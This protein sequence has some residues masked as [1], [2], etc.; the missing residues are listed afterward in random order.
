MFKGGRAYIIIGILAFILLLIFE[1]NKPKTINWFPSYVTT[2]KIPYGTKVIND[3]LPK[4]LP[5][6]QQVY[7]TPYELLSRK[8]SL[9]GTYVF[10]NGS[11]ELGATD[12]EFLLSWVS[13]GN[14]LFMASESFDDKLLDTF[15]LE[16]SSLYDAESVQPIFKH[17][18]VNS[19]LTI[20]EIAF[21]RDYYSTHFSAIDTTNS[22]IIGQVRSENDS[23]KNSQKE[24]NVIQQ[25]FGD[26]K[27]TLS[28]FPE[29]F[30]NYF[31]L[32]D[33]NHKYTGGLLSYIDSSL[34]VFIDNHHKSGKTFYTSPMYLFLNTRSFKWAYYLVLIGALI[35]VIFEGKRK[36][37]AIKIVT[38]LKNQTLAFTRTIA[39]M[40]FENNRQSEIAQ[41]KIQYFLDYI[42]NRFYLGTEKLNATFYK[43]LA[44]RSN[45]SQEEV[46][47]LFQ[48]LIRIQK[49]E[50][51]SNE[52]LLNL[53]QKIQQFKERADGK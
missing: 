50:S 30:T 31:V 4:Y 17:S 46:S 37:R 36:Q 39:N 13:D 18:L 11:I 22:K 48:D 43:A 7:R 19:R 26:G 10:V 45:H 47:I 16:I 49:A 28:T 52:Q 27:I 8:D 42:R 20:E 29:A 40:Y 25:K 38:P 53:E 35:Y 23:L 1:Y 2:H 51:I 32:K 6:T 9:Y 44:L 21:D 14:H 15:G 3:L 5:Q 34:P 41:H 33:K 24:V 12:L